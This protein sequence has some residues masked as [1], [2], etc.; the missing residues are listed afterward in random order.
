LRENS[1]EKESL[2]CFIACMIGLTA[3][4]GLIYLTSMVTGHSLQSAFP[5]IPWS[6]LMNWEKIAEIF[7]IKSS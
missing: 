3:F 5:E 4:L 6:Q 2:M 1:Y 7:S